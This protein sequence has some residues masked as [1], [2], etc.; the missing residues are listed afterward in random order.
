MVVLYRRFHLIDIT[1]STEEETQLSGG[2][3]KTQIKFL[4]L[5]VGK[6]QEN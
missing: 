1:Q 3:G 5:N 6:I 4:R 2:T